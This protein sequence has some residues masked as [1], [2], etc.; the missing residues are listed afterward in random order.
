LRRRVFACLPQARRE[1][2]MSEFVGFEG[3]GEGR[4]VLAVSSFPNSFYI[5]SVVN[6]L[7]TLSLKVIH[8]RSQTRTR[9]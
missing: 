1:I 6:N 8:G 5:L 7:P 9:L 2:S 4:E 3:E